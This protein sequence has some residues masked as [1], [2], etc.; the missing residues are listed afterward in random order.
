MVLTLQLTPWPTGVIKS[1]EMYLSLI[2]DRLHKLS[3][4]REDLNIAGCWV[5]ARRPFA[6]FIK[7]V[8]SKVAEGTVAME[9]YDKIT[10]IMHIDN[11]FD[12]LT[13]KDRK[14]QRQLELKKRVDDYFNWVKLKYTQVTHNSVNGKTLGY[15]INQEKYLRAF[16]SDRKIPMDNNY[17]LYTG[18]FYPHILYQ[19]A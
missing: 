18:Y 10:E 16:L 12:D 5:H 1:S 6:E 7:S 4:E 14:R 19:G 8:G 13:N 2:Y 17:A 11:S 15:S 3:D 9:A